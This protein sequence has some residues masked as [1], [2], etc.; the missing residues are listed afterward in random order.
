M[1][2]T[3]APPVVTAAKPGAAKPDAA[4]PDA[5]KPEAADPEAAKPDAAQGRLGAGSTAP[6]AACRI[7]MNDWLL[8]TAYPAVRA[9]LEKVAGLPG[10]DRIF[11]MPDTAPDDFG[12]PNGVVFEASE[13]EAFVY[14]AA[15]SDPNCGYLVAAVDLP[16]GGLDGV[17]ASLL[18]GKDLRTVGWRFIQ[19]L[20]DLAARAPG[21][22]PFELDLAAVAADG[23]RYVARHLG[24]TPLAPGGYREDGGRVQ[25]GDLDAI[26]VVLHDVLRAR[27][28]QHLNY[29]HFI[30]LDAVDRVWSPT[31]LAA[32]GL[33]AGSLV[34]VIHDG[35]AR[36]GVEMFKWFHEAIT[37][38]AVR[39]GY[40]TPEAAVTGMAGVPLDTPLGRRF[41]TAVK[42]MENYAY[43]R[44]AVALRLAL[45]ALDRA[46]DSTVG[47]TRGPTTDDAVNGASGRRGRPAARIIS[48]RPHNK[49]ELRDTRGASHGPNPG[50]PGRVLVHRHGAQCVE[51]G[52][53]VVCSRPA[54]PNLLVA[55]T[56]SAER[57]Y[58]SHGMAKSPHLRG[59]IDYEDWRRLGEAPEMAVTS[60]QKCMW[61][62]IRAQPMTLHLAYQ[63]VLDVVDSLEGAGVVRRVARLEPLFN[64][65]GTP[66]LL[67]AEEAEG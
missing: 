22:P 34:L 45:E 52:L 37:L 36:A 49:L 48:E 26:P 44:R 53:A 32:A 35:S 40:F 15:I 16:S 60:A 63:N 3:H 56:G 58:C 51:G 4:K 64:V 9:D 50:R 20:L 31:D 47:H 46:I 29:G 12:I 41:W 43:A 54:V 17:P 67:E 14:P 33:A 6:G 57:A 10:I 21:S 66:K 11:V 38:E 61:D 65:T 19:A 24:E 25:G 39:R 7:F 59:I 2:A 13:D 55:G 30:E 62:A 27:F 23:A 8:E 18:G 28:F 42:A 5:T 1:P